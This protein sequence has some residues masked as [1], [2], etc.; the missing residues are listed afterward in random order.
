MNTTRSIGRR[1]ARTMIAAAIAGLAVAGVADAGGKGNQERGGGK[2][3]APKAV[4]LSVVNLTDDVLSQGD[5]ITFDFP[6]AASERPYVKLTC[7]QGDTVVVE[8]SIG[9]FDEW[10]W[11]DYFVL[12][13]STWDDGGADCSGELYEL[14]KNMRTRTIGVT[15][16]AVAP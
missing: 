11:A 1:L 3:G 16:F 2:G 8:G 7:T 9:Y 5:A 13:S 6:D 10:P 14:A 15:F 12:D 4:T